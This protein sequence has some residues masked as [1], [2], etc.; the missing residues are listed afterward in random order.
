[1]SSMKELL[2]LRIEGAIDALEEANRES[3]SGLFM[4][5]F[6][7]GLGGGDFSIIAIDTCAEG[8]EAAEN[9]GLPDLK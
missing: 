3:W 8:A 5:G 1:M 7:D 9:A 4:L 2:V 6:C